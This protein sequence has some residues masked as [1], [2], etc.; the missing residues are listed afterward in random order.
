M[1]DLWTRFSTSEGYCLYPDVL[2]FFNGLRLRKALLAREQNTTDLV[3]GII[4]NSD[5]RVG[6]ILQS[7]GFLVSPQRY[8]RKGGSSTN[9]GTHDFDFVVLSSDVGFA[10]PDH[11]IFEAAK[12][13]AAIPG[14]EADLQRMYVHVGDNGV[15]DYQAAEQAGWKGVCIGGHGRDQGQGPRNDQMLFL[16]DLKDLEAYLWNDVLGWKRRSP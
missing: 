1:N 11:R 15:E 10:K 12:T 16:R 7:F 6:P 14:N 5:D 13:C 3:V 9:L 2:P 8:S 4:S